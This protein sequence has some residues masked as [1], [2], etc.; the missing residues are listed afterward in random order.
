VTHPAFNLTVETLR[1]AQWESPN[2]PPSRHAPWRAVHGNNRSQRFATMTIYCDCHKRDRVMSWPSSPPPTM[3]I[4]PVELKREDFVLGLRTSPDMPRQGFV[5][6]VYI[7]TC[8]RC[9]TVWVYQPRPAR[10]TP[11]PYRRC[12]FCLFLR[13]LS[14]G[15]MRGW[16]L[17]E[18]Q[19]AHAAG[20]VGAEERGAGLVTCPAC[21]GS[22]VQPEGSIEDFVLLREIGE[23][24]ETR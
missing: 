2:P 17:V 5:Q 7:G 3:Q 15:L 22:G 24:K 11:R 4:Q 1:T 8:P 10:M 18:R 13:D 14:R 12:A 20:F 21:K 23:E 16:G 6:V 19:R 9:H